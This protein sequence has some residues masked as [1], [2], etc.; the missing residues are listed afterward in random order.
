MFL[1]NFAGK[2]PQCAYFLWFGFG[3]S[4]LRMQVP[5][6]LNDGCGGG[7]S[8]TGFRFIIGQECKHEF[9][10]LFKNRMLYLS[11]NIFVYVFIY[12]WCAA[13]V[14]KIIYEN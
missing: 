6:H 10:Y 1:F 2:S 11:I 7:K 8:L 5:I 9:I 4:C 13:Q 14:H 12:K 3:R